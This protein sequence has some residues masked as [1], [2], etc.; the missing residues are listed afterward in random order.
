MIIP[1]YETQL[2]RDDVSPIAL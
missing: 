2:D 1:E